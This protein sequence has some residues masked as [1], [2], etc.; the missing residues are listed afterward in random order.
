[1]LRVTLGVEGWGLS[2]ERYHSGDRVLGVE[3]RE[4]VT[5]KRRLA[6]ARRPEQHGRVP[7][8][9]IGEVGIFFPNKQR[10]HRTLYT[11]KDALPYDPG[12]HISFGGVQA[13]SCPRP[14]AQTAS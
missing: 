13:P 8:P 3:R 14:T 9:R 12:V 7:V 5:G 2:V 10:Q 6:P 11:Q 4:E 1:M